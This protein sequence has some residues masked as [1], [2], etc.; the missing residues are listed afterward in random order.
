MKG[1]N[2]EKVYWPR[3]VINSEWSN[4]KFWELFLENITLRVSTDYSIKIQ[5]CEHR[6]HAWP[7]INSCSG[8]CELAC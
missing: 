3:Y 4:E 5:L 6:N 1:I 8:Y 7:C 2:F